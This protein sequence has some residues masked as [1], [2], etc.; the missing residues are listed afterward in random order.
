VD[1]AHCC[2]SS[3]NENHDRSGYKKEEVKLLQV[4]VT[5]VGGMV[6]SNVQA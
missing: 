4:D 2:E 6:I 5:K 3:V 1:V